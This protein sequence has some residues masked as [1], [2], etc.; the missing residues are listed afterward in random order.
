MFTYDA[1]NP[2]PV[3]DPREGRRGE[4]EVLTNLLDNRK[5]TAHH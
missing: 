2:E 4:E 5:L 3:P 1:D